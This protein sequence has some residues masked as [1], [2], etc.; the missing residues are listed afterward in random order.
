[1]N[2]KKV[3]QL[4]QTA[5]LLAIVILMAFTP[6]GYLRVGALSITF[7]TIPVVIGAMLVGPVSGLILG[8]AFGLTS[9]VQAFLGD[10]FA[11]TLFTINPILYFI[12]CVPT[13]SLVG[14]FSAYLFRL[15][16]HN[17]GTKTWNFFATGLLGALLN[18]V[19]FMSMLILGFFNTDVIQ[20]WAGSLGA[21]GILSFLVLAVG[22]NGV[23]EMVVCCIV[24]GGVAKV[25]SRLI[26]RTSDGE[27]I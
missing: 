19:F 12:M 2:K 27:Y 11:S 15:F 24:G 14:L 17:S 20:A 22:V 13:R 8:T 16:R 6:L 10:A 4:T 26:K 9:F 21:R 5:I 7:N 23:V 25:V 18:T 1:M 3:L